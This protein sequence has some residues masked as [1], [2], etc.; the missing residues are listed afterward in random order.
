MFFSAI[1]TIVRSDYPEILVLEYGVDHVGEMDIQIDIVEPDILLFTR[2]SPSHV[3]GF[4]TVELYYAE[5]QKVLRRAHKKTYAIG[6]ADDTNQAEFSCQI[7]Y[8]ADTDVSDFV[9]RDIVEHP[10]GIEF[11]ARFIEGNYHIVSPIL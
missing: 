11:N 1:S 7:W 4:G 3:E 10:D 6:N 5:K 8:G 9:I 2:L